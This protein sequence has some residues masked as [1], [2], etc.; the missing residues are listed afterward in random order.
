MQVPISR[1]RL[2]ETGIIGLH[3]CRQ[4]CVRSLHGADACQPQLLHQPV[5]QRVMGPFHTALGLA[6]IG[7]QNLDVELRQSTAELSDAISAGG[8]LPRYPK[9]RML[10]GIERHR[11]AMVLQIALHRLEI[12]KRALGWDKAKLHHPRGGLVDEHQKRAG[13]RTVLKP[14]ML[15]TVDLDQLTDMLTTVARLLDPLALGPRQP[16]SGSPHPSASSDAITPITNPAMIPATICATPVN[17]GGDPAAVSLANTKMPAI[18][19]SSTAMT[20]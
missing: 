6:G 2:G 18:R 3:E 8:I 15:R 9:D 20:R 12:G 13:R 11:L 7:A 10:V 4:K 1:R 19:T 14:A 5:L 17:G 16:N